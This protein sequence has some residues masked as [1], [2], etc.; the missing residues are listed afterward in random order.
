MKGTPTLV[1]G[2]I[3]VA[4][5]AAIGFAIFAGA[6]LAASVLEFWPETEVACLDG[7][8]DLALD[9]EAKLIVTSDEEA[10]TIPAGVG[11][12]PRCIA[13]V[14]TDAEGGT[15]HIASQ[16]ASTTHTLGDFFAV[17]GIPIERPGYE[18][19]ALINGAADDSPGAHPFTNGDVIL[20]AYVSDGT[21]SS[22]SQSVTS[23]VET[24]FPPLMPQ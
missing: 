23:E 19:T 3:G 7:H 20:F 6:R 18:L 10:E 4:T 8:T 17:A 15:I 9:I 21:A 13:E 2:I 1:F 24:S 11:V 16:T 22:T 5:T 12:D 14:H